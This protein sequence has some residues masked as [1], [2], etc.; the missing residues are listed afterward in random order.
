MNSILTPRQQE[1]LQTIL[2]A[3]TRS[4][5]EHARQLDISEHTFHSHL[6]NIYRQLGVGK[7]TA[8]LVWAMRQ[9]VVTLNG[10][11]ANGRH[12]DLKAYLST[13]RRRQ[14]LSSFIADPELLYPERAR[15]LGMSQHTFNNHLRYIYERLEVNNLTA[16][17]VMA[18]RLNVIQVNSEPAVDEFMMN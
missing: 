17:L 2:D 15:R 9:G 5:A 16:A 7:L 12:D 14:V 6:R 11:S 13:P 1:V 18:I 4:C 3:P 10:K 8:A